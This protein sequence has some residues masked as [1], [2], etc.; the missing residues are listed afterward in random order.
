MLENSFFHVIYLAIFE[1][2]VCFLSVIANASL[3]FLILYDD[4]G[5]HFFV[6]FLTLNNWHYLKLGYYTGQVISIDKSG[7]M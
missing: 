3:F 7:E 2:V 1:F 4:K 5:M 6:F